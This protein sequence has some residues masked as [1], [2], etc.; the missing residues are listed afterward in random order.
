MLTIINTVIDRCFFTIT[1]ILGVQLPEFIQQ[2]QQRLSG[3]LNEAKLQLAQFE[4]IAQQHFDGSL[5]SMITRYKSNNEASIVNTGELIER[6]LE[7]IQYLTAHLEQINTTNYLDSLYRFIR[8]L[9]QQ[10]AIA[11]AE[12]FSMAI[13]LELEAIATGAVIAITALVI[14]ELLYIAA[15][16]PFKNKKA[17][18]I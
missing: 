11:T 14:K 3:H 5:V 10:I 15:T 1:F 4:T 9:D 2:Y 12:H 17:D 13:P 16:Y 18:I 8:H 7:R 6:L